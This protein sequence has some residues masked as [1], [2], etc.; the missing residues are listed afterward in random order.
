M[1]YSAVDY[2]PVRPGRRF[3]YGAV[4]VFLL[5]TVAIF[6]FQFLDLAGQRVAAPAQ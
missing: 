1:I 4:K 6:E 3:N 5:D 2:L